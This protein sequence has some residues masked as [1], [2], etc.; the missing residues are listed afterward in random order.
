M[1]KR[2][3]DVPDQIGIRPNNFYERTDMK[4][5]DQRDYKLYRRI[6]YLVIY[7]L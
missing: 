4:I 6:S 2:Y 3:L 7:I 5:L 1:R